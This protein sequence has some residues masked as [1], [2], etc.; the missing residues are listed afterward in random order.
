MIVATGEAI[1]VA[2]RVGVSVAL[3]AADVWVAGEGI[4]RFP[5]AGAGRQADSKRTRKRIKKVERM[6]G[7]CTMSLDSL[8]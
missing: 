8:E 5:S 6:R 2:A 7:D 4:G 3:T 1:E